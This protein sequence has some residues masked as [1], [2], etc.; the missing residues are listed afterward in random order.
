MP[1]TSAR[2]PD[3]GCALDEVALALPLELLSSS[4]R[5]VP[6][7]DSLP[8]RWLNELLYLDMGAG[9]GDAEVEE[10]IACSGRAVAGLL[11]LVEAASVGGGILLVSAE[12]A[13]ALGGSTSEGDADSGGALNGWKERDGRL[14]T[15]AL[16]S[17]AS[18]AARPTGRIFAAGRSFCGGDAEGE[19]DVVPNSRAA[20]RVEMGLA[21]VVGPTWWNVDKLP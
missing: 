17:P 5:L 8:R 9:L 4:V 6:P 3:P 10:A 11:R 16:P 13:G 14:V 20:R 19:G 7:D 12:L 18:A 2:I 1:V 21:L 15:P